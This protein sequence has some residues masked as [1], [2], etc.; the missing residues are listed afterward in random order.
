MNL[1]WVRSRNC[2]CLVTWFC[3]QLIAKPG[4]KTAAVSWPD[5]YNTYEITAT[6]PRG[7]WVKHL[8][9]VHNKES[10]KESTKE[11]FPHHWPLQGRRQPLV[12]LVKFC[13]LQWL[14]N[15]HDGISNYQHLDCL[16]NHLFTRRSK[17]TSKAPRHWPLCRE[18]TGDRWIPCT[19]GQ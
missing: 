17:K 6:S 3:Y 18:F 11:P 7:Q 5:P 2:G 14:H 1:I 19:K 9:E 16:L 4:N 15:E 13:P 10:I 12:F 8:F